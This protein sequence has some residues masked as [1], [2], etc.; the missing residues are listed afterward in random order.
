MPLAITLCCRS[1]SLTVVSS[2]GLDSDSPALLTTRSTPP[3]ASERGGEQRPRP[4]PRR[5]RRPGRRRRHPVRPV[6]RRPARALSRFRSAMT[7]TAAL[8][9]DPGGDGLADAGAGAGDQR[10]PGGQR[11]RL[12]H[13][14]QLGLFQ[15]P[16]LDGELLRLADRGVGR[17]RFGAAHHV[18]RVDVELAGDPGGLLVLAEGEHPDPGHQHDRRVRTAHRRGVRRWRCGRSSPGS[19]PGR[20]RAAPGVAARIS[21]TDAVDGQV[22]DQRLDLGPQEVVRARRAQL[23]QRGELLAGEEVQHHVAVGEVADLRPVGRGEPA[24]RSGTARRPSRAARPPGAPRSR[25][26]PAPNGSAEPWSARNSSAV[27]MISRRVRLGLG[28]GVAPG[29][30]AVAAEDARRWPAGSPP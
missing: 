24:D 21:S 14:L 15:R 16:V 8:G 9:G 19:R 4:R 7:T 13:P 6:R 18:D 28:G 5:T 3:N 12:R 17:H 27:R 29:G 25:A 20:P 10:D 26:R 2:S 11:L 23:G 22:H 30:D 1:Q